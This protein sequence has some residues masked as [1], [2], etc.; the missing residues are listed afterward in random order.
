L[1]KIVIFTEK[2]I[3]IFIEKK[4]SFS[5]KKKS[6]FSLKKIVILSDAVNLKEMLELYKYFVKIV[7]QEDMVT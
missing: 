3:G 6:S 5:L 1:I 4:S 7:G 2:K